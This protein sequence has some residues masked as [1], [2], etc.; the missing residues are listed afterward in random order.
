MKK[1]S[2]LLIALLLICLLLSGCGKAVTAAP[3]TPSAPSA[4]AEPV[5]PAAPAPEQETPPADAPAEEAPPEVEAEPAPLVEYGEPSISQWVELD[6][7]EPCFQIMV[8]V[9]NV[10]GD[11]LGHR[12]AVYTLKDK[13]GSEVAAFEGADCAPSYLAPGESGV[14]YYTAINRSGIDYLNPDYTLEVESEF[15]PMGEGTVIPLKVENLQLAKVLGSIEITCELVNDTDYE[16]EFPYVSFL[17]HDEDGNILSAAFCIAGSNDYNSEDFGKQ[18]AGTTMPFK[19]YRYWL[20]D[21]YPLEKAT[22]EA[23]GFG[24][25]Y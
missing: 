23:F 2:L 16:F 8:P 20:P 7:A 24:L 13:D 10:S 19:C 22:V 15:F 4:Q 12:T 5:T 14:I 17:F 18:P 3:E 11:C 6:E 9:T 25:H 21:D 1:G